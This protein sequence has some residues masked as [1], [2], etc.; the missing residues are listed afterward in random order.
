MSYSSRW[1]GVI[2]RYSELEKEVNSGPQHCRASGAGIDTAGNGHSVSC[3]ISNCIG[4]DEGKLI[5]PQAMSHS[6]SYSESSI[7]HQPH[8]RNP[9]MQVHAKV[10]LL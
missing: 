3:L 8:V 4:Q 5:V 2:R 10:L 9:Y 1:E 7:S 6:S